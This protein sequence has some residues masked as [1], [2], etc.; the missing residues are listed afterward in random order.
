MF[1][2]RRDTPRDQPGQNS[3]PDNPAHAAVRH[4]KA[5]RK[6]VVLIFLSFTVGGISQVSRFTCG[7]QV[8]GMALLSWPGM[9]RY[10]AGRKRVAFWE[11]GGFPLWERQRLSRADPADG[12]G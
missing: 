10:P 12:G 7:L 1:G 4:A 5:M 3:E 2:D 11:N 8:S 9:P 6:S